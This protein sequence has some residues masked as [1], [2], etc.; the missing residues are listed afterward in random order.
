MIQG[1][2]NHSKVNNNLIHGAEQVRAPLLWGE[3]APVGEIAIMALEARF[4][5]RPMGGGTCGSTALL[6]R[7]GGPPRR[8][9]SRQ[10]RDGGGSRSRTLES[11][12]P[13]VR[14]RLLVCPTR[15]HLQKQLL[16]ELYLGIRLSG[17]L[18]KFHPLRE[19]PLIVTL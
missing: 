14:G 13:L 3:K 19:V 18:P 11:A 5:V 1:R 15:G 16:L 9:G 17:H 12:R 6:E 7:C 2:Y 4:V 10:R 8:G